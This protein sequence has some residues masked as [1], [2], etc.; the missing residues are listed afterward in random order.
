MVLRLL[1]CVSS[2]QQ[3]RFWFW[4]HYSDVYPV[5]FWCEFSFNIIESTRV[6]HF[7]L[8]LTTSCTCLI[9]ILNT[10]FNFST[11][12]ALLQQCKREAK[13]EEIIVKRDHGWLD[14]SVC[15]IGL[16]WDGTPFKQ[17]ILISALHKVFLSLS[18]ASIYYFSLSLQSYTRDTPPLLSFCL[19]TV[20]GIHSALQLIQV[21]LFGENNRNLPSSK[22]PDFLHKNSHFTS[23]NAIC[24]SNFGFLRC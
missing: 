16:G 10:I 7:N 2:W 15:F 8:I 19:H 20:Q 21:H 11:S 13:W 4:L 6:V 18:C 24:W 22:S 23:W 1:V 14:H 5:Q 17:Y 9:N 12:T 3:M